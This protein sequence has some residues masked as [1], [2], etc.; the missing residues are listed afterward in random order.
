[1]HVPVKLSRTWVSST[2]GNTGKDSRR[3]S[4]LL[5]TGTRVKNRRPKPVSTLAV[6]LTKQQTSTLL[7]VSTGALKT[8]STG[9]WTWFL[10]KTGK[11]K[12]RRT[13]PKTF[14]SSEK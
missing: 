3:L 12:G 5:P 2:T 8:N 14:P 1:K 11:G 6:S 10:T 7:Y 13:P 4:G 9:H